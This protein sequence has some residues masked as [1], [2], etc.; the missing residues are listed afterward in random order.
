MAPDSTRGLLAAALLILLGTSATAPAAAQ[1]EGS[2]LCRV[3][4]EEQTWGGDTLTT[5]G[6]IELTNAAPQADGSVYYMG[7]GEAEI[8]HTAAGACTTVSGA[9]VTAQLMGIVSSEDRRTAEVDITPMGDADF[10]TTVQCGPDTFESNVG[11][12]VPPSVTLPFRDGASV[13][14]EDE[15]RSMFAQ[16][17]VR[18]T[19]SLEFCRPS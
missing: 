10:P 3:R 5:R 15:T 19:V 2:W 14:Y 13:E 16:G 1:S 11:V 7:R 12:S 8:I 6:V 4:F 18:G 17:G 9:R